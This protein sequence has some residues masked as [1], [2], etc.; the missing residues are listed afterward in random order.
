MCITKSYL[1]KQNQTNEWQEQIP[2]NKAE[3]NEET[4]MR[5]GSLLYIQETW[6]HI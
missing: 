5:S 6:D 3:H 2:Q 4:Q 1:R